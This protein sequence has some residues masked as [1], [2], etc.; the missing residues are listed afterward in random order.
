MEF[1]LG[2]ACVAKGGPRLKMMEFLLGD[3][4]VEKGGEDPG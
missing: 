2:D 3:A 1:L 4:C